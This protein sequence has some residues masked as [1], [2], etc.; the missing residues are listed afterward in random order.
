MET[1][2]YTTGTVDASLIDAEPEFPGHVG[3]WLPV[4]RDEGEEQP[5]GVWLC[6]A[7]L[8]G[9][10]CLAR[11]EHRGGGG[12]PQTCPQCGGNIAPRQELQ[13]DLCD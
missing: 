12:D 1:I 11:F 4:R 13:L 10:H 2:L 3:V 7:P 6:V 5:G 9:G 8:P